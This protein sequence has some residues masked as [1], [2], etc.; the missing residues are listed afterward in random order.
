MYIPH[1]FWYTY[2]FVSSSINLKFL[3]SSLHAPML[4]HARTNH[5]STLVTKVILCSYSVYEDSKYVLNRQLQI[6]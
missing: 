1:Q 2:L 4:T 3:F 5:H 6:C